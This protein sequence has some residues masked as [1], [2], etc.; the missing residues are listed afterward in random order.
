MGVGDNIRALRTRE[1]LSQAEL[2]KRLSVTK[3]TVSRWETSKSFIR[4]AHLEKFI[5]VFGVTADDVLSEGLGFASEPSVARDPS[6]GAGPNDVMQLPYP[7]YKVERS[8]NGTTLRCSSE[9]YAPLDVAQRHP[10]GI[11]VRMDCREMTRLYPAG[12]LL[13]VDQKLRPWNGCTVV[14]YL[15]NATVVIRRYLA[16][17]NT[18]MLSSW[19]YDAPAPDLMIDRRRVRIV[20]VVVWYQADHDLGA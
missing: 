4:K 12:S 19:T 20:G 17:N 11:F 10:V 15:D 8:G 13:L 1:H 2:A 16:G 7:V 3:E 5:E 9:A 18:I 6:S 14:A